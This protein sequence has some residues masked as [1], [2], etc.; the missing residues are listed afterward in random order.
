M[1]NVDKPLSSELS[2]IKHV[3]EAFNNQSI[4]IHFAQVLAHMISDYETITYHI[5]SGIR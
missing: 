5:H 1:R 3:E 2:Q 4:A